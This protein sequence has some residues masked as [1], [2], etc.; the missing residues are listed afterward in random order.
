MPVVVE[1]GA[2]GYQVGG[3]AYRDHVA[4]AVEAVAYL[5]GH[6]QIIEVIV[7]FFRVEVFVPGQ[8]IG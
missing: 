3:T 1:A 6:G 4:V 7:T 8:I 5:V 2:A